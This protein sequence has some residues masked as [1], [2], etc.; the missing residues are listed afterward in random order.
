[1]GFC[2]FYLQRINKWFLSKRRFN[3]EEV[4][5]IIDNKANDEYYPM[6]NDMMQFSKVL[7]KK[8]LADG[9]I[10]FETPEV[11]FDLDDTG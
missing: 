8:R 7:T 4:Q 1:M 9:G 5:S 11:E 10:D 2:H 3:Y 6:L